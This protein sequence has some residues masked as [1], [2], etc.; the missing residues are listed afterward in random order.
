MCIL[1]LTNVRPS[2]VGRHVERAHYCVFRAHDKSKRALSL[3]NKPSLDHWSCWL[4][5]AHNNNFLR[6]ERTLNTRANRAATANPTVYVAR[7]VLF[8][9][10]RDSPRGARHW[11]V[12]IHTL[13]T[14]RP[15]RTEV[16]RSTYTRVHVLYF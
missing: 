9:R 3:H 15:S 1:A 10:H 13:Q 4:D 7:A 11:C 6:R 12:V 16:R 2:N 14:N 5:W 8:K